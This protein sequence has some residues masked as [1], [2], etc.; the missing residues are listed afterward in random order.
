MSTGSQGPGAAPV[1]GL[2]GFSEEAEC[3]EYRTGEKAV[4]VASTDDHGEGRGVKP[5]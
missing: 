5:N 3:T 2:C 1:L 4:E